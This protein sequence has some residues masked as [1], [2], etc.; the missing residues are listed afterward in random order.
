MVHRA[1]D[2]V[3]AVRMGPPFVRAGHSRAQSRDPDGGFVRVS[4]R[5]EEEGIGNVDISSVTHRTA[6]I[7]GRWDAPHMAIRT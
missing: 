7:T 5:E 3:T 4:A 6:A 1:R 2:T